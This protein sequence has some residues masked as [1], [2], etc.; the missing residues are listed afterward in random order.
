MSL[1]K[2]D[3]QQIAALI[4]AS[5][6]RLALRIDGTDRRLDSMG[7]RLD[8]LQAD[9]VAVKQALVYMSGRLPGTAPGHE[10]YVDRKVAKILGVGV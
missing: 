1:T 10:S 5:E 2:E 4:A 9:V 3:L 6:K 7:G 8:G